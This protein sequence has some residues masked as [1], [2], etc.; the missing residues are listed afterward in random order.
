MDRETLSDRIEL[1]MD[2]AEY[3]F[4]HVA[5]ALL[6]A[7]PALTAL[8]LHCLSDGG[9]SDF[10]GGWTP[11]FFLLGATGLM[12]MVFGAMCYD[13]MSDV[14]PRTAMAVVAIVALFEIGMGQAQ[15]AGLVASRHAAFPVTG[16]FYNPGPYGCLVAMIMPVGLTML[17]SCSRGVW[18]YAGFGM[19]LLGVFMLPVSGSRSAW[20]SAAVSCVFVAACHRPQATW[21]LIKKYWWLMIVVVVAAGV[22]LYMLKVNSADG[23]LLMWKVGLN[24][25]ANHPGG[26]GWWGVAGAYGEAQEAYFAAADRAWFEKN[27]AD[28]PAYMFNEYLQVALAWGVVVAVLLMVV[29]CAAIVVAVRRRRVGVAGAIVAFMVFSFASYP[30]QFPLFVALLTTLVLAAFAP[31]YSSRGIVFFMVACVGVTTASAFAFSDY[32]FMENAHCYWEMDRNLYRR[33]Y[34]QQTV[35]R[36]HDLEGEMSW[37]SHYLFELGHSLSKIGR[38][39]ESNRVLAKALRVSSDPMPLNVMGSNY[40][41]LGMYDNAKEMYK[42]SM[43]RV[44]NRLY[45]VYLMVKLAVDPAVNDIGLLKWAGERAHRV[46]IKVDSPATHDM[47]R[48]INDI[49]I[50]HQFMEPRPER[51]PFRK[52]N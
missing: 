25:V 34:Y 30:L 46:A 42:R 17:L 4:P 33:Q 50:E 48:E 1:I 18:R 26:V 44:P 41:A 40:Q 6:T 7:A 27:V 3:Y 14:L 52:P 28:A 8:A 43:N 2:Y 39:E 12:L 35:D 32:F 21:R 9:G 36:T 24:A 22:G 49:L 23:R 51:P 11:V 31:S 20:I 47:L 10:V 16:T 19:L 5:V 13:T 37:N 29:L 45:P 15:I 38:Y